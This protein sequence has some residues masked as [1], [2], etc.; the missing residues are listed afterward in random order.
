MF[1][2]QIGVLCGNLGEGNQAVGY[3]VMILGSVYPCPPLSFSSLL[4][5]LSS[6]LPSLSSLSFLV[7][8]VASPLPHTLQPW[9]PDLTETK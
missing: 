5:S 3:Q 2:T 6:L 7:G 8:H 1:G 4:S 9:Y